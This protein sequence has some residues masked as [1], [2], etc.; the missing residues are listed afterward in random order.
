MRFHRP[1]FFLFVLG[2]LLP[3]GF[4]NAADPLTIDADSQY[5]FAQ[6]SLDAGAFDEAIAEF[7]RFIHFFPDDPRIPRARFQ[8]G[9]AHYRAGRYP[10][11][12][13][14][15]DRQTRNYEGLPLQNE[16]YFMLS[17]S[18]AD[19]GRIEQAILDLHN[20][21]A[22]AADVDVIDRARYEQGWLHVQQGQWQQADRAFDAITSANRNGYRI[23]DLRQSLAAHD[24]IPT[25]SPTLA[26][27]LSI[28]P[29][30]G[31]LYC[32][33]YR[34]AL[35][36]FL[37]NA[38]L[39]LAAWEAFDND[40]PALGGVI[41][42]VEFGFYAGNIYGAVSSAHKF[43]RDRVDAFKSHL[44]GNRPMPLS[45]APAPGGAALLLSFDF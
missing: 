20:L 13:A 21:T 8:T 41:T 25:K 10:A 14:V 6:S 24:A 37:V 4:A 45:L 19:Q 32:N 7:N 28:V 29:G 23:A 11:A 43:N 35:T 40:L 27:T 33:R 34:D 1:I 44:N 15:F 42:F 17:R 5:R 2:V 16:A 36:A 18:H 39:I 26:G 12:A 31:Q 22:V 30:G 38:G 3:T 9:I